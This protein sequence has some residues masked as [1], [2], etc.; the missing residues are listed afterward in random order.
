MNV[1][2]IYRTVRARVLVPVT[3]LFIMLANTSHAQNIE[4][5]LRLDD[6][7]LTLPLAPSPRAA[8]RAGAFVASVNDV[9]ALAINPAGLG[10]VRRLDATLAMHFDDPGTRSSLGG[11][12]TL[13]T[14][15]DA[16]LGAL[17]ISI[18]LRVYRGAFS[19]AAGVF[20]AYESSTRIQYTSFNAIDDMD[21]QYLL[22]QRGSVLAYYVGIGG[23]I[24]SRL[25]AGVSAFALDG[26][27]SPLTQYTRLPRTTAGASQ[28][29]LTDDASLD[30]DG[31]GGRVGVQFEIV[32]GLRVGVVVASPIY[33]HTGGDALVEVVTIAAGGIGSISQST[34]KRSVDYLLPPRVDG[35][36]AVTMGPLTVEM[37]AGFTDW[38]RTIVQRHRPVDRF[39]Q[40][41]FHNTVDVRTGAVWSLRRWPVRVSTGFAI[42]PYPLRMLPFDRIG[43][44]IVPATITRQR[45]MWAIGAGA[46][47]SSSIS[48]DV[49]WQKASGRRNTG[50][51]IQADH[52]RRVTCSASWRF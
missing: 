3:I 35:G 6:Y 43:N 2:R 46:L 16:G 8:G 37:N 25:T 10:R 36:L 22:Q 9:S 24:A 30:V 45:H 26:T 47:L 11:I 39:L 38:S 12:G 28:I 13:H 4:H 19:V 49:A 34:E 48:V 31:V 21:E 15:G 1:L 20:R 44:N 27:I 33:V 51:Y 14:Q 50:G 41:E 18:P 29:F 32:R 40:P 17:A 5:A 23:E 7:G 42:V 52:N